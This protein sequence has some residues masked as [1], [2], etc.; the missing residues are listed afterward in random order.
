MIPQRLV[1]SVPNISEGRDPA[2]IA[3][4]TAGIQAIPQVALLDVHVDPDHHR[5]V[6][7]MVGEPEAMGTALFRL[8]QK[9]QQL[10][11]IR[12][13]QGAH[14]RIGVVDV[15]PWVPFQGVSMEDCVMYAE[16][17]GARV[18]QEL[19][20]PVYLYEQASRVP[21]RAKLERIRQGGLSGLATRMK[22]DSKWSPDY[23][24]SMMHP[25]AGA[26]AVGTRFFLI[27]F[28]VVLQSD[29]LEVAK[30]IAQ[31]IRTSNGGLPS[32]KAMGVPLLSRQLVQVSMN[33]TDFRKTSL[34][35]AFEFVKREAHCYGVEIIE[36]EIVGLVPQVAWDQKLLYDLKVTP[37]K[38]DP[39]LENRLEQSTVF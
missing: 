39:I 22:T 19:K 28:N 24:P 23:G 14:P 25:T 12:Q 10:I 30:H 15:V 35:M 3:E 17:L 9:A 20:I 18:G 1:E 13:H 34:R 5:S 21:S 16:D 29:D 7:T 37:M 31:A 2:V 38:F 36:S 8:V 33:L 11:D 4:L 27:A 6:F 32:V 26:I